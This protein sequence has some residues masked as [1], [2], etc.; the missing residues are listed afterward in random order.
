MV[1][2]VSDSVMVLWKVLLLCWAWLSMMTM[3]PGGSS[4]Q[5]FPVRGAPAQVGHV[6]PCCVFIK[7]DKPRRVEPVLLPPPAS[8]GPHDVG[9]FLFAGV[10]CLFL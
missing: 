6:C 4:G 2:S 3:S 8:L 5:R 10:Q 1:T 9:P 7:E